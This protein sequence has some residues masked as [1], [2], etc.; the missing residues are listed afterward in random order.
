MKKPFLLRHLFLLFLYVVFLF[1]A[2]LL[3]DAQRRD[4]LTDDEIE[5]VRDA[6]QMDQR[7]GVL[8]HAADRRFVALG[9]IA[10]ESGEKRDRKDNDSGKWGAAPTGTRL[11]LLDDVRRIIQKA[12]DDIDNLATRPDSMVVELPGKNQKPK[13]YQEIFPKAVHTLASAAKRYKPILEKEID[14]AKDEK[15]KGVIL[16]SL[17]LCGQ[18]ID[19]ESRLSVTPPPKKP[20]S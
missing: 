4:Y 18:I 1:G 13:S 2:G 5:M 20:G 12:V 10:G 19:A 16:Q 3:V 17:D 11:E 8:T 15:V 9:L 14:E 6:Q 7:V